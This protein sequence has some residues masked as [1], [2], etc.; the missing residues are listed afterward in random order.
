MTNKPKLNKY[1][2][3]ELGQAVFGNPT[4]IYELPEFAEALLKYLLDE[5]ERIYWNVNQKKW[6][7]YK[8][9]KSLE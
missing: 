4:G 6:E 2:E 9:L 1:Y 8:I 3:P 7:G 5:I